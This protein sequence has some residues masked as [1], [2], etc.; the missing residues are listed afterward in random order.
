[1]NDIY[2][3][4]GTEVNI[5]SSGKLGSGSNE[6]KEF[7]TESHHTQKNSN[8]KGANSYGSSSMHLKRSS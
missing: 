1:M 6:L 8:S 2:G 7:L 3:V 5:G 4:G